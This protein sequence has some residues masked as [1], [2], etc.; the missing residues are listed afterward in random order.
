MEATSAFPTLAEELAHRPRPNEAV[1][2]GRLLVVIDDPTATTDALSSIPEGAV[3]ATVG[4]AS[5]PTTAVGRSAPTTL[6]DL[7]ALIRGNDG[8]VLFV[9]DADRLTRA[10]LESLVGA[11]T[12]DTACSTVSYDEDVRRAAPG[13]P[14]PG[15]DAPRRGVVLVRRGDLL[16]ATDEADMSRPSAREPHGGGNHGSGIVPELLTLLERPGFVHRACGLENEVSKSVG[17][18]ERRGFGRTAARV[19]VDGTCLAHA[20]TGTQVHALALIGGLVRAGADVAVMR[21]AQL[22]PTVIPSVARL[23]SDVPFVETHEIGRPDVFH[24]PFQ[25]ASLHQLA[26]SLLVGERLVLTHQDMI[27][28]RTPAYHDADGAR[29]YRRANAAALALADGVAFFSMHAA[30]D[31]ASD[32][33]LDPN[34]ATVVRPGVDHLLG[35]RVP[36]VVARPFGGR[37]YLLM[38]GSAFWHKNRLFALRVLRWLVEDGGWEGGLVFVGGDPGRSSSAPAERL[39][40]SRHQSVTGR[41]AELGHVEDGELLALYR[42]AE[43]VLF[44]SLYEGFGLV[45][46][47][48]AALGTACVYARRSAMGELL[49]PAGCL[50]SFDVDE[51]GTFV[52]GLLDDRDARMHIVDQIASVASGLTW[53]RTAAGYLEVY[54]RALA[55]PASA[56]TGVLAADRELQGRL[57][58]REAVLIDVYRRRHG[59]RLLLDATLRAGTTALRGARRLRGGRRP[60]G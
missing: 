27:W 3:V 22:H 57:T 43:L 20:L 29:D 51:A 42:D 44:P 28:D 17:R 54:D 37:P 52:L 32:G 2:P 55:R 36:E 23:A 56:F 24:R 8:D 34:R 30:V 47:E 39:Y 6:D 5:H 35:R 1:S 9:T 60:V 11:L 40:L 18:S 12:Q 21:P 16:L 26:D 38:V 50:P 4:N 46:F 31:A 53:D 13:L 59:V 49:P 14:P 7:V 48:A 33:I 25:M 10:V 45:P 58:S 19:L 15:I 41:V